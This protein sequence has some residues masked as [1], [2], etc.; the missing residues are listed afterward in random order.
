MTGM[1]I[2]SNIQWQDSM[3]P[4]LTA[5]GH[6]S[7]KRTIVTRKTEVQHAG[8]GWAEALGPCSHSFS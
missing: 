2:S 6:A 4:L 3:D 5:I 7:A 8:E 1:S